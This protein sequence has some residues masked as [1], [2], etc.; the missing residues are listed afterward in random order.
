MD[1]LWAPWR[2]KYITNAKK[3]QGC[4]FCRVKKET[5]DKKN[6]VIFRSCYALSMLNK[7]PYNNGH[8]MVIPYR[9]TQDLDALT[10]EEI[11]DMFFLLNKTKKILK[12]VLK[13]DGFNVGMN[14]GRV[15]GAGIPGHVHIH[16][17]PRWREDTNFMPVLFE[18]KVISQSLE[19]LYDTL[20]KKI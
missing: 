11:L 4:L 9:H 7:F 8:L 19:E 3:Q 15:A 20:H 18:T 13:P 12:K 6:L 2:I 16:I 10:S 14:L 1:K 17:V 5:T